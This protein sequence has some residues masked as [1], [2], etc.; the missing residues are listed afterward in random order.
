MTRVGV[1]YD[2]EPVQ[3][4]PE[5]QPA[6]FS[7]TEYRALSV[8]SLRKLL[9]EEHGIETEPTATKKELLGMLGVTEE[10]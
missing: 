2:T 1:E 10:D 8:M 4:A 9:R 7:T 5:Q 3:K 6:E